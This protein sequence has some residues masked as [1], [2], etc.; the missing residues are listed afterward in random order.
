M[1][2]ATN[3]TK[4]YNGVTSFLS[5]LVAFLGTLQAN[6]AI[7]GA[8]PSNWAYGIGVGASAI[9]GVLSQIRKLQPA[10]DNSQQLQ[11]V[12]SEIEQVLKSHPNPEQVLQEAVNVAAN[13]AVKQSAEAV[14]ETAQ[15][16][17][18]EI[19]KVIETYRS[20]A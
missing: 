14:K 15:P 8:V 18:D 11:D 16:V 6:E 19:Q 5:A 13:P 20:K 2:L 7:T 4:Y 3:I 10:V 9:T 12:L 1:A 17:V